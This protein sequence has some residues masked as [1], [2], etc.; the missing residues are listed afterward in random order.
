[1]TRRHLRLGRITV[2]A[3]VLV[4][5]VIG[6]VGAPGVSLAGTGVT[7]AGAELSGGEYQEN[8]TGGSV[9]G[10]WLVGGSGT[11]PCLTA[12]SQSVIGAIPACRQGRDRAGHGVLRL[13][14][15]AHSQS[16]FVLYDRALD[17]RQGLSISFDMYQYHSTTPKAGGADGI[18]FIL[19]DGR[20]SP[21]E[22][23]TAGF[24]LG[25][26]G[27]AGAYLGIGLDEWGNYSNDAMWSTG[28]AGRAP[29]SIVVRGAGSAGYPYI[30]GR[31]S[32][33]PFALDRDTVRSAA[34]RHVVIDISTAGLLSVSVGYPGHMVRAI[35]DL[36]LDNVPGQPSLP[37]SIKFGFA[38]STG[39]E[40]AVHDIS[41][42]T[43]SV[44]PPSL[45]MTLATVSPFYVGGTGKLSAAVTADPA[46]GPTTGPVTTVISVPAA[47]TPT[48]A[49]GDGWSCAMAAR[50]VSC[51]HA[52][53]LPPGEQYPPITVTTEVSA[54]PPPSVEVTGS[55]TTPGMAGAARADAS[56][57]I[58]VVPVPQPDLSM[59]LTP[60]GT[61]LVPGEGTYRMTVANA[62]AAGPTTGPVTETFAIPAGQV[63]VQASGTGWTCDIAGQQV[64][65][66]RGDVLAPGAQYPPVDVKVRTEAGITAPLHPV[67]QVSTVGDTGQPEETSPP[68]TLNLAASAE[69][70]LNI[71]VTYNGTVVPGE[72]IGLKVTD[73]GSNKLT[74]VPSSSIG[75]PSPAGPPSPAAART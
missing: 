38:A 48:S 61:F 43:I 10:S 68:L 3:A 39:A 22:P 75:T 74:I 12:G 53:P 45:D 66:Y 8:F 23:G 9:G 35:T 64:T 44:L 25:Y 50:D 24:G 70:H 67:A 58:P 59:S 11:G 17:A 71:Q 18:S 49:Q 54:N 40:T 16:G 47:L 14:T 55:A 69:Q 63:P 46:G 33:V 65:C 32:A 37:P 57:R 52:D 20:D 29:D 2:L 30:M 15:N 36:D 6:T 5:G 26:K 51:V 19:I 31:R 56:L 13:T 21:A 34:R 62:A 7:T 4:T 73:N 42:L 60:T 41:G 27:L 28:T 1:M 72:T